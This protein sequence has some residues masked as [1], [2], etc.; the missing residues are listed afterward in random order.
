MTSVHNKLQDLRKW[1]NI[2]IQDEYTNYK[3]NELID[4][5]M[6]KD[7]PKILE[8]IKGKYSPYKN[9]LSALG[10]THANLINTEHE[11]AKTFYVSL[12]AAK[13]K[14]GLKRNLCKTIR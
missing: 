13:F 2:D 9:K 1:V 12:A 10:K 3:V 8:E 4:S 7:S 6:E 11:L 14:K 5:D